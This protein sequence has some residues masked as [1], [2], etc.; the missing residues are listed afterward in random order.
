M[1]LTDDELF[2][3]CARNK[4]LRI[5]RTAEGDL[6]V[7]S[8]AGLKS[9][10]RNAALTKA[11]STWAEADGSG[12]AVDSSTGFRLP[13]GAMRAPD[14]AWILRSRLE[15]IPADEQEKFAPLAPDFV[16]ELLS[17]SDELERA[18]QKMEEWRANGVR[19]GWLLDPRNRRVYAY[20]PGATVEVFEQPIQLA[21][22]PELPGFVL[23]LSAVWQ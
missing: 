1:R 9:G 17:P 20:R 6:I 14:A 16:I 11:L 21:G 12:V 10:I 4:E 22:D 7:M 3:L 5:E 23:D 15:A 19:L 8:P 13:N 2:E 18:Q